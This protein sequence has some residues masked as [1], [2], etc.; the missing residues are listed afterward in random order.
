M[1]DLTDLTTH[2]DLDPGGLQLAHE[3]DRLSGTDGI[4]PLLIWH[5]WERKIDECRG[6]DIDVPVSSIY[7]EAA[8]AGNLGGDPFGVGGVLLGNELVMITLNE[9]WSAPSSGDCAAQDARGVIGGALE[10]VGLF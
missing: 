1:P 8:C 9:D 7:G 10:G 3:R 6:V 2:A 4:Y 5:R